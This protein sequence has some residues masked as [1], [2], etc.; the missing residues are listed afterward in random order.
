MYKRQALDRFLTSI[1][2]GEDN[3]FTIPAEGLLNQLANKGV[4]TNLKYTISADARTVSV[5]FVRPDGMEGTALDRLKKLGER[6][7]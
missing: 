5:E 1:S 7:V 3:R 2:V 6:C 4:D